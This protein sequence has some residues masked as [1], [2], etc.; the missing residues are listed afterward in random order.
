MQLE[1]ILNAASG[2]RHARVESLVRNDAPDIPVEVFIV[3][4]DLEMDL[5]IAETD[6]PMKG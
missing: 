5:I 3:K 4:V 6:S 2:W 1:I